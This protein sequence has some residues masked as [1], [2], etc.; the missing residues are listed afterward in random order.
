MKFNRGKCKVLPLGRNPGHQYMLGATQLESSLAEKTLGLLV[1]TKL[2]MSQQCALAAKKANGILGCV[3]RSVLSK[4]REVILPPYSALVRPHLEC[5]VQ[6]LGS[7]VQ[8]RHGVLVLAGIEL[9]FFIV[10]GVSVYIRKHFFTVKVTKHLN[11]LPRE[12]VESPSLE[13][14]KSFP[15]MVGPYDL[16][17]SLPTSAIL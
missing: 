10:A 16:Q 17:R 14:F 13:I 2:N 4:S 9:I 6:F 11:S 8:E 1:D 7:P 5:C 3:G 12:L 15:D